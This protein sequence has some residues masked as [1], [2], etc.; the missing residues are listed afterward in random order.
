[1]GPLGVGAP[2]EGVLIGFS[3]MGVGVIGFTSLDVGKDSQNPKSVKRGR[4]SQ[5]PPIRNQ[6]CIICMFD[7]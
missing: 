2:V 6:T 4:L 1:M 3:G 5:M 7:F